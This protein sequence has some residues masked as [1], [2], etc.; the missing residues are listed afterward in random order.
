MGGAIKVF[1][2]FKLLKDM[3]FKENELPDR[4][5]EVKKILRSMSMDYEKIH[6]CSNDCILYRKEYEHLKKCS[7]SGRSRYKKNDKSPAKVLWYFP[8][9]P[10]FKC[11]FK[12]AEH[13][14]S[15]TCYSDGMIIDSMLR[16]PA[17]SLQ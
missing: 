15:L 9:M 12:N 1:H 7:V 3:L 2:S 8:I 13:A 5:D 14:K 10:R 16:H 11:M 4:T 17:D 6:A